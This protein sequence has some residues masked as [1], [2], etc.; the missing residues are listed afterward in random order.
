MTVMF[1]QHSKSM[2]VPS[3]SKNES[4]ISL[5]RYILVL[6]ILSNGVITIKFVKEVIYEGLVEDFCFKQ[7]VDN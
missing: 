4:V 1:L 2:T 6:K 7:F 3:T 5:Y